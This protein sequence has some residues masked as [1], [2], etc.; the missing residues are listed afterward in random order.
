MNRRAFV[1][2]MMTGAIA[3]PRLF[4]AP[5]TNVRV[6]VQPEVRLG[7]IPAD[8]M[9]LGYEISSVSEPGLLSASNQAYVQFVR[10]L[11]KRGV[12]RIGGNTSDYATWSADGPAVSKPQGTVVDN[13]AIRDL[14]TFL[15]ATGWRLIW[16]LNLGQ[17]NIDQA[18][19]E[20]IAVAAA[21][22]ERLLALEIGNEPDMFAGVHR[23]ANYAF[24]DYHSE[25]LRF[26]AA[27][28][29]NLPNA[30]F[31]GPDVFMRT[32]WLEQFAAAESSDLRLLTHHY[33]AEGPQI[34]RRAPSRI[35]CTRMKR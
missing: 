31:A 17:G 21:V 14:V 29:E 26:K 9:G 34:I 22:G 11:S 24:S 1:S 4:G 25:Y 8:F 3:G 5:Q 27:I 12:I 20:A 13:R 32:D 2:G 33:Y 35:F 19:E 18:V 28:R 7:A 30:P 6:R 16:G 15:R 23:P 10:T